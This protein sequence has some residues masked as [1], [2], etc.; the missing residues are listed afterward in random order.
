MATYI[1]VFNIWILRKLIQEAEHLPRSVTYDFINQNV[2][3]WASNL[4]RWL[5]GYVV[6]YWF[7]QYGNIVY[8]WFFKISLFLISSTNKTFTREHSTVLT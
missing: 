7:W 8:S 5:S 2:L 4:L 3:L 6:F 1:A